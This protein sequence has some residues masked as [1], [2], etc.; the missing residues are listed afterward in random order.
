MK[1]QQNLNWSTETFQIIN[2]KHQKKKKKPST[3]EEINGKNLLSG[4][5]FILVRNMKSTK[6]KYFGK[7]CI[8]Q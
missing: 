2:T 7:Y 3:Q 6:I 4:K 5:N 8:Y 1:V